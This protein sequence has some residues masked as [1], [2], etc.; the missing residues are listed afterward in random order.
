MNDEYRPSLDEIAKELKDAGFVNEDGVDL[1][2]HPMFIA[3]ERLS[4]I[5]IN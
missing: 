5:A 1:E 4:K 3:L 2:E